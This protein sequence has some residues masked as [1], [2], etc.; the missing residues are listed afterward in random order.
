MLIWKAHVENV[1]DLSDEDAMH[2]SRMHHAADKNLLAATGAARAILTKLGIATPHL[3]LHIYPVG[4]E[5]GRAEVFAI[6]D[7]KTRAERDEGLVETLRA[8]LSDLTKP[9]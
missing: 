2:F 5:L 8:L 4:A 6:I 7:G 9:P 1:S 3:H